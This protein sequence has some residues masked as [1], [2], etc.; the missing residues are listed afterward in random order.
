MPIHIDRVIEWRRHL[1]SIAETA[2]GEFETSKYVA[3]VLRELGLE[4]HVGIGGTGVVGT[5]SRGDGGKSIGLRADLDGLPLTEKSGA[6]YA[7]QAPGSMHACGHDGHMAMVLG[8]AAHLASDEAFD[9]KV[10]FVF[11][12]AEEPGK[13]AQAMIDDG[14]FERFPMDAMFGIHNM[15]GWPEGN[16]L[17][18]EGPLMASEDNFVITITGRGGHASRPQ[19]VIDPIVIAA[20]VIQSLQTIIS[21]SLDPADSGVI[22]CTEIFTDGSRN[23]IP[24]EVI[25]KGD[26]RSFSPVVQATLEKRMREIVE[27]ICSTHGATGTLEYTFEFTPTINDSHMTKIAVEAA[28]EAVGQDRVDANCPQF[29]GSEDFGVFANHIPACFMFLGTGVDSTP[30]HNSSYNFNDNVL[31]TGIRFYVEAVK[32]CSAQ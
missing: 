25:I 22:S 29:M 18:R 11:Q 21:R 26:T 12:P 31:E 17:T 1:H 4:V 8:A 30:L 16:L 24:N 9:G 3:E 6:D 28:L 14:L 13:G 32:M 5:L 23:A 7:P 2:F 20:E 27:G 19:L 10:H 15:P